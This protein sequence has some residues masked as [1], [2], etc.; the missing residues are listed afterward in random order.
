MNFR[1]LGQGDLQVQGHLGLKV[2][3]HAPLIWAIPSAGDLHNHIGRRKIASLLR[4]LAL[5]D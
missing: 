2:W 4:L 1:R 5:W 3:W